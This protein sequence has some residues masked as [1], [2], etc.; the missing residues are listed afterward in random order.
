M[1]KMLAVDE[2]THLQT[3]LLSPESLDDC[4]SLSILRLS[5]FVWWIANDIHTFIIVGRGLPIWPCDGQGCI[6]NELPSDDGPGP[7]QFQ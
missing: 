2:H 3:A 7:N 5:L 4:A 6:T 1:Q